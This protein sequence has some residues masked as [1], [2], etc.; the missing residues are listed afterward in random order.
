MTDLPN[1]PVSS[2]RDLSADEEEERAS[3]GF[4]PGGTKPWWIAA[5]VLITLAALT[6]TWFGIS[7]TRGISWGQA[8]VKVVNDRQVDVTFDVVDQRDRPVRCT[9]VAYDVKHAT[10][11]RVSVELP[12]SSH[13][14][15]RY[16]RSVRTVT[17]AVTGEVT[18]CELR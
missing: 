11:G 4:R 13:S 7:A 16:T 8:G 9:L 15:T 18:H 3:T 17:Q 1:H 2:R 5:G 14:S 6:A 10:V 12:P